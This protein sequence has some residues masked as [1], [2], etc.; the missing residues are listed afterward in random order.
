MACA[1]TLTRTQTG[2]RH[3]H[4]SAVCWGSSEHQI[5]QTKGSSNDP[6]ALSVTALKRTAASAARWPLFAHLRLFIKE[7]KKIKRGK[8]RRQTNTQKRKKEKGGADVK[9]RIYF[10]YYLNILLFYHSAGQESADLFCRVFNHS[11]QNQITVV[12]CSLPVSGPS[13][14]AGVWSTWQPAPRRPLSAGGRDKSTWRNRLLYPPLGW[15]GPPCTRSQA[16]RQTSKCVINYRH[17]L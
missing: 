14:L 6:R 7:E 4:A 9:M 15:T 16:D 17:K 13:G 11:C 8:R 12:R 1:R 2:R 3:T 5:K 10:F